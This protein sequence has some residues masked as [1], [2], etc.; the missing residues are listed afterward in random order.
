MSQV[1]TLVASV[2]SL[3]QAQSRLAQRLAHDGGSDLRRVDQF[4]QEDFVLHGFGVF[5]A[6][7]FAHGPAA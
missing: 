6:E 4:V 7:L 2:L 1:P 3:A 5:D